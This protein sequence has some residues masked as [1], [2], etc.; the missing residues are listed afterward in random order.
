MRYTASIPLFN[1]A[2][3]LDLGMIPSDEGDSIIQEIQSNALALQ[4]I[5]NFY[6]P[7]SELS[8]L[9]RLRSLY[10]SSHLAAVIK[11]AWGYC[12]ET[13]GAYDI[14]KGKNFLERKKGKALSRVSCSYKDISVHGRKIALNHPDVQ[15]DLG[16]IAKGYIGDQLFLQL[17]KMKLKD[18]FLDARGD[19]R[20]SG[21]ES[22]SVQHPRERSV[23]A[24]TL[25]LKNKAV[26][27]SGDYNQWKGSYSRN[28]II[29][30]KEVASAT[31]IAP[32]LVDA[33]ACA[34]ILMVL[35]STQ[36]KKFFQ[37]HPYPAIIINRDHTLR[38]YNMGMI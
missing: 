12:D 27:T 8:R 13:G 14:S 2:L 16:S 30:T 5:F 23:S 25:S 21:N 17:K 18:I 34:T 19:I 36:R 22:V 11:Q 20:F 1:A 7:H 32:V 35:D 15:I 26:A 3:E 6:D 33:D 31:V 37:R 10:V 9:N 29:G 28:H 24:V 38:K 4:R